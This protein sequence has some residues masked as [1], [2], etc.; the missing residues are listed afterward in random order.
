MSTF[1]P[2]GSTVTL[3][4]IAPD[5]NVTLYPGGAT[6]NSNFKTLSDNAAAVSTS[7][8]GHSTSLSNL[9]TTVTNNTTTLS[10]VLTTL[11]NATASNV[12]STIMARDGSGA[13]AASTATLSQVTS[14][15]ALNIN[16]SAGALSI[17]GD[18]N[19]NLTGDSAVNLYSDGTITLHA[20][21]NCLGSFTTTDGS[22]IVIT[23]T[24]A[25]D[26]GIMISDPEGT[27]HDSQQSWSTEATN[28]SIV[29]RDGSGN[30]NA[31]SFTGSGAALTS[32]NASN[33][34]TGT[35][36]NSKLSGVA[37]TG[38]SNTFA[39]NQTVT[40]TLTATTFS[41]SGASLTAI[42]ESAVTSLTS[43]L[44]AKVPTSRTI[45]TT[46]PL[47]GSGTLTGNIT[48]GITKADSSHDGYLSSTDWSTFNGK[49][50]G[51]VTSVSL[52]ASSLFAVSGSPVTTS[53]AFTLS[54]ASTTPNK[55]LASNTSGTVSAA[56]TM[57]ALV[58]ADLP[59]DIDAN[60]LTGIMTLDLSSGGGSIDS[61]RC[62]T[63]SLTSGPT[64]GA[65]QDIG[66]NG[67][68]ILTFGIDPDEFID[69]SALAMKWSNFD[70]GNGTVRFETND[71]NAIGVSGAYFQADGFYG[72]YFSG[73]GSGLSG[74]AKLSANNA[75]TGT[76]TLTPSATTLS[77]L[78]TKG[79]SSMSTSTPLLAIKNSGGTTLGGWYLGSSRSNDTSRIEL[80]T[81]TDGTFSA[82][83]TESSTFRIIDRNASNANVIEMQCRRND[84]TYFTFR[85]SKCAD[86][87]ADGPSVGSSTLN[88]NFAN[89]QFGQAGVGNGINTVFNGVMQLNRTADA[90][91]VT[92]QCDSTTLVLQ[93]SVWTGAAAAS[94]SGYIV[95]RPTSG[96]NDLV[97]T[98]FVPSTSTNTLRHCL[99][100][101]MA[102]LLLCQAQ[103][104]SAVRRAL[105]LSQTLPQRLQP[106][107]QAAG[108]CIAQR[109]TSF[110][111]VAQAQP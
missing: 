108:C 4:V 22:G 55:V 24:G 84:F 61:L 19:L 88:L 44:A 96:T 6:L 25:S 10:N 78:T 72:G 111:K 8:S 87:G 36:S 56:P 27:I 47:T 9:T 23:P 63:L 2:Y 93:S 94:R 38:S 11:T 62:E 76:Q 89:V 18:G 39:A 69:G 91:T 1:V 42:P 31:T 95:N 30:I 51:S 90:G 75:F 33:I 16:T 79:V 48:L 35:L 99:S 110:T 53:G 34:T 109:A 15:G 12:V 92:T 105:S 71:G 43:D 60:K 85:Q 66:I 7:L 103:A 100:G 70:T 14:G 29:Q 67:F 20:D 104:V 17:H 45:S 98:A 102:T 13:F 32:L 83:T 46:A 97:R 54:A 26:G 64:I 37:L 50:S 59:N 74:V 41:G 101:K 5:P 49:G 58:N 65:D 3:S 107:R 40:G 106:H 81:W 82:N 21:T 77:A 73:D 57:R 80:S 52:A 68:N 86:Y 28:G